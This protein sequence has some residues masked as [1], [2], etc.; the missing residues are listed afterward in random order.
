MLSHVPLK[1]CT[2]HCLNVVLLFL[3]YYTVGSFFPLHFVTNLEFA[4]KWTMHFRFKQ[5]LHAYI[6]VYIFSPSAAEEAA[7]P[8]PASS[9]VHHVQENGV[10]TAGKAIPPVVEKPKRGAATR[11]IQ[12]VRPSVESL[13]NELES[14]VPSPQ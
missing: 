3:W 10:P 11:G 5:D 4:L 8:L 6:Y 14:S 2:C 9:V 12:D 1:E 7:P 13:L